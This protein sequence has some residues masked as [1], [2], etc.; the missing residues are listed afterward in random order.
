L[1]SDYLWWKDAA[2]DPVCYKEEKERCADAVI[3][4]IDH[5]HPG[6]KDKIEVVDVSTPLTRE[7]YTRNWMGAMQARKPN[8]N[9]IRS[10]T[11]GG[12]Q[13]AY[14]DV[15]GLYM[16]G[17]WVEA[18]GGITTAAQSGRKAIQAMCKHDGKKFT[19]VKA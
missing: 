2:S 6:F 17:Q 4:I 18:W 13:Y 16:A 5:Y 10:L 1:D 19:A 15:E 8:A 9:I 14:K 12:P 11:Q 7:Y 3:C